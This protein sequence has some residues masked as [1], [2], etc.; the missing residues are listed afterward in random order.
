LNR[1]C[2]LPIA[3]ECPAAGHDRVASFRF[4]R[5]LRKFVGV[6]G[7]NIGRSAQDK[8]LYHAGYARCERVLDAPRNPLRAALRRDAEKTNRNTLRYG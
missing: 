4:P 7:G 3:P 2:A 1:Q 5:E 6:T 8:S